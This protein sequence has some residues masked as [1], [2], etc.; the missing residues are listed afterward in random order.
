MLAFES[1][2]SKIY[3]GHFGQIKPLNWLKI[4]FYRQQ[5]KKDVARTFQPGRTCQLSKGHKQGMG[6]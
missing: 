4:I 3:C 5:L 6:P 1:L 2:M